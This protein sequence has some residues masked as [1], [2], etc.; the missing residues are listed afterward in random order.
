MKFIQSVQDTISL[1]TREKRL[2]ATLSENLVVQG[3]SYLKQQYQNSVKPLNPEDFILVDV[4]NLAHRYL[5]QVLYIFS[6]SYPQVIFIWEFNQQNYIK[7]G[8]EGRRIFTIKNLKIVSD[9]STLPKPSAIASSKKSVIDQFNG[10]PTQILIETNVS[11]SSHGLSD[12]AFMLPYSVHPALL[13]GRFIEEIQQLRQQ[14]RFISILFSGNTKPHAQFRYFIEQYYQV[15][16]RDRTVEYLA[17]TQRNTIEI[18]TPKQRDQIITNPAQYQNNSVV[19]CTCKGL[20]ENW[21]KE[22]AT[23]KFFLAL[24]GLYMLM[25]HNAIEAMS[26]GCIPIL[27]YENWFSPALVHRKNCLTYR[28]IE[29][30]PELIESVAQMSEAEISGMRTAVIEYFDRYLAP[31]S[32]ANFIKAHPGRLNLYVNNEETKVLQQ[33]TPDSILYQGGMLNQIWS[34]SGFKKA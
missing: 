28:C 26:V 16:S 3:F 30:L 2:P 19:L 17:R 11:Q 20:A 15:P 12:E 34:Q 10:I 6:L 29:E 1:I 4:S 9:A 22:L 23:A 5:Y 32:I 25:C 24:P 14:Q 18:S 8:H 13:Q 7:L 27:C 31:Q 21:L 33:L